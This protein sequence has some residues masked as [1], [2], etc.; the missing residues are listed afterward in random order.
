VYASAVPELGM[1]QD[2]GQA[3]EQVEAPATEGLLDADAPTWPSP[4]EGELTG[5]IL[6]AGASPPLSALRPI[7]YARPCLLVKVPKKIL[8]LKRTRRTQPMGIPRFLR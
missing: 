6:C 5:N 2:A 8:C 3:S 4:F 1:D 7:L